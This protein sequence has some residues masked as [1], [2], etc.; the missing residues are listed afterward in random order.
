MSNQCSKNWQNYQLNDRPDQ[1]RCV[2]LKGK[3]SVSSYCGWSQAGWR[4]KR[5]AGVCVCGRSLTVLTH[6]SCTPVSG[7][8]CIQVSLRLEWPMWL[9][10]SGTAGW[11]L[12]YQKH[13]C[14]ILRV[15]GH[16]DPR[17]PGS[18]TC[19]HFPPVQRWYMA[20]ALRGQ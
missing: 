6:D 17:P 3:R 8:D 1:V 2:E 11:S 10:A 16:L 19:D 4:E 14:R 7:T 12:T 5:G 13:Y 15:P 18:L 9:L 20:A